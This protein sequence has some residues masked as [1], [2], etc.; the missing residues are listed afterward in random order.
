MAILRKGNISYNT[1]KLF[2]GMKLQDSLRR[3]LM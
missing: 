1:T 3:A 2:E